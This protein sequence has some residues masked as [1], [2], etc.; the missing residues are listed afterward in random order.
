MK[1]FI[2][3]AGG[4]GEVKI[5]VPFASLYLYDVGLF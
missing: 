4:H 5:S 3:E 2:T 1:L